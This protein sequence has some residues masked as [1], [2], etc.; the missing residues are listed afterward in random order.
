MFETHCLHNSSHNDTYFE[1][2][3]PGTCTAVERTVA[4]QP[5][6]DLPFVSPAASVVLRP[7]AVTENLERLLSEW[8]TAADRPSQC[9]SANNTPIN[10]ARMREI[11]RWNLTLS[12]ENHM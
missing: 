3:W 11:K 8:Y 4:G 5:D 1:L 7:Q 6:V 2:D 9:P 10:S 12:F